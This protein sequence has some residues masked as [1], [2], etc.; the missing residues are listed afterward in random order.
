MKRNVMSL[1][2]V[3]FMVV[4]FVYPLS[5][6]AEENYSS[7]HYRQAKRYAEAINVE[8]YTS[9]ILK[10]VAKRDNVVDVDKFVDGVMIF[11]FMDDVERVMIRSLMEH[12]TT[13][14]LK[15]LADFYGTKMGQSINRKVISYSYDFSKYYNFQLSDAVT[16]YLSINE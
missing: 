2:L 8:E 16:M 5:A 13:D 7:Q 3:L 14:E 12:F 15:V 10:D 9:N 1:F 11:M 4:S 6:I